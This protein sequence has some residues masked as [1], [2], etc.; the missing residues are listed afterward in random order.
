MRPEVAYSEAN[1]GQERGGD[2]SED[3]Y[4]GHAWDEGHLESPDACI[5]R[6]EIEEGVEEVSPFEASSVPCSRGEV[7]R[8]EERVGEWRAEEGSTEVIRTEFHS[9]VK[10]LITWGHLQ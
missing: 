7:K 6:N 8:K 5:E 3:V 2:D 10:A 1:Y 9:E 4:H